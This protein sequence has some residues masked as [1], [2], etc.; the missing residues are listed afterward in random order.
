[1]Q[2]PRPELVVLGGDTLRFPNREMHEH[3]HTAGTRSLEIGPQPL[4]FGGANVAPALVLSV[5]QQDKVPVLEIKRLVELA[6]AAAIDPS[7]GPGV[8]VMVPRRLVIRARN[9][10]DDLLILVPLL[11]FAAQTITVDQVADID[12]QR[13]F[14]S[15]DPG[16]QALKQAEVLAL[17]PWPRVADDDEFEVASPGSRG[18][19]RGE[20]QKGHASGCERSDYGTLLMLEDQSPHAAATIPYSHLLRQ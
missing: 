20:H 4:H 2:S 8:G 7:G 17:E 15:I 6:E 11:L 10:L 9:G 5:V 16:D 13:R 12:H 19:K 14:E 18:G 3:K 1:M